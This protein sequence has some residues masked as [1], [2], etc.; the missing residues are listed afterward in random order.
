MSYFSRI[1]FEYKNMASNA[2]SNYNSLVESEVFYG[3]DY[4]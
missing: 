1:D 2:H 3:N 4:C